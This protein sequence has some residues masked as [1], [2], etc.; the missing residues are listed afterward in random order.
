[1]IARAVAWL[2]LL[3]P[4]LAIV[5]CGSDPDSDRIGAAA[6]GAG[7]DRAF[8]YEGI[9]LP[10]F[11]GLQ[12]EE[13]D[14]PTGFAGPPLFLSSRIAA[15][16]SSDHQILLLRDLAVYDSITF[17][18]DLFPMPELAADENGRIVAVSTDGRVMVVDTGG[19]TN[20]ILDELRL[21]PASPALPTWPTILT[22]GRIIVGTTDGKLAAFDTDG[23]LLWRK[24][25]DARLVRTV[26]ATSRDEILVALTSNDFATGDQILCLDRDGTER[27]SHATE[28]RVESGPM[29][30]D[31][32][33]VTFGQA[34][35][36]EEGKYRASVAAL[37]VADGTPVFSAGL[38][39]IP[40]AL[41]ADGEG[42]IY[43]SG[44]GGSRVYGGE[45]VSFDA[46]G[47]E[48]WRVGFERN[49]PSVLVVTAS[50]VCFIARDDAA[51]GLF[52]YTREGGFV[53]FVPV[54][55]TARI[56]AYPTVS[57]YGTLML[58]AGDE[59]TL[60]TGAAAGGF[61]W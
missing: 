45:V 42:N 8:H 54:R 48:R 39:V 29:V 56:S 17:D 26:A 59:P 24:E 11:T 32:T 53:S 46:Q 58:A 35:Q 44:G 55:S 41:A 40:I 10:H 16:V 20:L 38:G 31:D 14:G 25:F 18:P 23:S 6:F 30:V 33:R 60:L 34:L 49:G 51:I 28:G 12:P 2:L 9:G 57:P 19:S 61:L 3:L 15:V 50:R 7:N 36:D 37:D 13:I 52:L 4:T 43:V 21:D 47:T 27:W 1:M 22:D 5:G